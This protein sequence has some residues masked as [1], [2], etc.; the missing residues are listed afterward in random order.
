MAV[1][2]NAALSVQSEPGCLQFDVLTPYS[3][4]D[5]SVF[6]Y[7]IYRDKA[8]FDDHLDAAHYLHFAKI[9][10]EMVVAK[11][12]NFHLVTVNATP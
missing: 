12:V 8:A 7:E 1:K 5:S 9:T 6:L 11:T 2:S 10:G 3:E 4:S